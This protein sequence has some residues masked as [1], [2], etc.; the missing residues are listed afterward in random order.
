[1]KKPLIIGLAV[2]MPLMM[3]VPAVLGDTV[4]IDTDVFEKS[5]DI[6]WDGGGYVDVWAFS[7]DVANTQFETEG[8]HVWGSFD[9]EY[10][11]VSHW[12]VD[13]VPVVGSQVNAHATDVSGL[14]AYIG[15]W[16]ERLGPDPVGGHD[17]PA[18]GGQFSVSSIHVE[19]GTGWLRMFSGTT[20]FGALSDDNW[21]KPGSPGS[22]HHFIADVDPDIG[23]YSMG[24]HVEASDGDSVELFAWGRGSAYLN[25][26]S[27]QATS[28]IAG[29]YRSPWSLGAR[30]EDDGGEG[31]FELSGEGTDE[32][33]KQPFTA[34]SGM[35]FTEGFSIDPTDGTVHSLPGN[36]L[37]GFEA[38]YTD[39]F[40]IDN[41]SITA[42]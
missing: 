12:G 39:G 32:V 40:S 42:N 22:A 33:V 6:D 25:S 41:Y 16:Q 20:K 36:P 8:D 29:M 30:F 31:F 28:D 11:L 17:D 9:L 15:L 3:A 7:D 34:S 24:R 5:V 23:Y 37:L 35:L 1:M 2:L 4:E 27:A 21:G 18:P 38:F 13:N 26:M 14:G 10:N 19:E